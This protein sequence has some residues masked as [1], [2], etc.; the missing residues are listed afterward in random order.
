MEKLTIKAGKF[1]PE[2]INQLVTVQVFQKISEDE[3]AEDSQTKYVG[4][5]KTYVVTR[6]GV[7]FKL[8]DG[9]WVKTN[10]KFELTELFYY[11]WE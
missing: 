3:I 9:D 11:E 6:D 1:E 8:E 10:S 5:L 4:V 2:M 7:K